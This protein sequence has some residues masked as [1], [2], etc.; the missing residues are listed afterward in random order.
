[1]SKEVKPLIYYYARRGW[2][3]QLTN[4]CEAL[5]VKKQDPFNVFWKAFGQGMCGNISASL[6]TLDLLQ[7]RKDMQYPVTIARLYFHRRARNIDYE[8]IDVLSSEL[9]IAEEITV[10]LCLLVYLL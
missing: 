5:R 8:A 6:G 9:S 4:F 1:M 3:N 10:S 7:S 2:Y